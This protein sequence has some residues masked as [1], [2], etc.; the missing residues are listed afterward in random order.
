MNKTKQYNRSEVTLKNALFSFLS[1]IADFISQ[2]RIKHGDC[3]KMLSL[4]VYS[5][6]RVETGQRSL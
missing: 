5:T 6:L 4:S 3:D 1:S 2:T